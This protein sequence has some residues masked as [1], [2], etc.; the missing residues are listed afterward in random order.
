MCDVPEI[1]G[2]IC[3]FSPKQ[4]TFSWRMETSGQ[5]PG[6]GTSLALGELSLE[7]SSHSLNGDIR[8]STGIWNQSNTGGTQPRAEWKFFEWRHLVSY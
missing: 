1:D 7:L 2:N 5:V 3:C 4:H 6:C 8:S